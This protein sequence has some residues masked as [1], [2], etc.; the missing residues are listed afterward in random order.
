[1]LAQVLRPLHEKFRPEDHPNLLGGISDDAAVYK[2]DAETAIVQ[3]VDFFPPVVDDAWTYGAIAAANAMSDVY[4][5]GGEV[6]LCLNIAGFPEDFSPE[7]I[8]DIFRGGAEKVAEGGGV[9]AGGHTLIDQEP[10]YGMSVMGIVHPDRILSKAGATLGDALVL[11]KAL[12]AGL[13]LTAA[14]RDLVQPGHLEAAVEGM[15]KLNRHAMHLAIEAGAHAMTDVTGFGIAG[16]ALEIADHSGVEVVIYP[17]DL[18]LLAGA[19]DYANAGVDF[20]GVNRNRDYLAPRIAGI[21]SVPLEMQRLL[22]DPQT[23]GGLLIALDQEAA[24]A[25]VERLGGDGYSAAVVGGVHEGAG[26][27]IER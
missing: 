17:A 5:M 24:A 16:H 6:V 26:L 14:K 25:L 20:G 27:R 4:A 15:L 2:L 3:T 1:M 8:R 7:I 21:E 13:I 11:T 12:G 22:F 23:S 19:L 10:K 18:P 9:V